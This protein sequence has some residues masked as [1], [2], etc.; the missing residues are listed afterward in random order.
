MA[1]LLNQ[2]QIDALLGIADQGS[3]GEMSDEQVNSIVNRPTSKNVSPYNFKRPRLFAQDQMRVQHQVHEVFSRNL[4]VYLSAQLQTIV[5][6]NLSALDQ[7]LYAEFVMASAPPTTLFI[8]DAVGTQQQILFEIDPRLVIYTVEKLF[9]GPGE[10]LRKPRETSKI[11]Q[12]IMSKIL[13]RAFQELTDAWAQVAKLEFKESSIE[14]SAEFI[15]ILPA[16]EPAIVST[17][18]V[19]VNDQR[20]F[21][22]ICYPYILL[23]RTLGRTGMKQW[24]RIAETPVAAEIRQGF[25]ENVEDID[26]Q[27][28]AELGRTELNVSQLLDL[29]AGDVILLNQ[30]RD[31]PIHVFVGGDTH[32]KAAAG[33]SGNKKALRILEVVNEDEA[34]DE[35]KKPV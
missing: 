28:R 31:E 34:Q 30:R 35:K 9:G 11:E 2:S 17:F 5:D 19:M 26:M 6:V 15:Q 32:F 23:E 25:E 21:I 10:F 13:A 1:K 16:T 8:M 7:V 20:S 18:E 29:E 22:N 3:A 24:M 4:S 27:V 33:R 12:R 14:S